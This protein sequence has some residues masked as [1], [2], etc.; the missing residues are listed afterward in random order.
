[1]HNAGPVLNKTE[2]LSCPKK[3]ILNSFSGNE[4]S[5]LDL[6]CKNNLISVLFCRKLRPVNSVIYLMVTKV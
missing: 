3:Q 1:M 6:P 4:N 2:K 5:T